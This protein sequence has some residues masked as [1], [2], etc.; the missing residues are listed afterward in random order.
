MRPDRRDQVGG[1]GK[2]ARMTRHGQVGVDGWALRGR[3]ARSETF[4]L[5]GEEVPPSLPTGSELSHSASCSCPCFICQPIRDRCFI[6]WCA[7]LSPHQVGWD[8][9]PT[10]LC[11]PLH[12]YPFVPTHVHQP[13]TPSHLYLPFVPTQPCPSVRAHPVMP[14]WLP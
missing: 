7:K 13:A 2:W 14:A 12:T 9:L 8:D 1:V 4:L 5:V 3:W 6:W 10:W 11:P